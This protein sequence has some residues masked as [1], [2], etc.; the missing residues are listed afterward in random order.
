MEL[1]YSNTI[2]FPDKCV[3]CGK[4]NPDIT[5]SLSPPDENN[6]NGDHMSVFAVPSCKSCAFTC[7]DNK[8]QISIL[9]FTLFLVLYTGAGTLFLHGHPNVLYVAIAVF[10]VS[11]FSSIG[12]LKGAKKVI[13]IQ[14]SNKSTITFQVLK[15]EYLDEFLELNKDLRIDN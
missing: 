11:L 7:R 12:A 5:V 14:N 1:K 4:E 10:L 3:F 8:R 15:D 2:A 6:G 13:S 9:C